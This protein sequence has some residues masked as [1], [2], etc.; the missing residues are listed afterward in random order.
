M[1]LGSFG[2]GFIGGLAESVD[3]EIQK[4][5][6][7]TKEYV[8][9]MAKYQALRRES[10]TKDRA[11]DLKETKER[12]KGLT[13]FAGSA[14]RATRLY[15][16][17]GSGAAVDDYLER[18]AKAKA[19]GQPITLDIPA[20][21]RKEISFGT[22]DEGAEYLTPAAS[23]PD[24]ADD[25][26]RPKNLASAITGMF[27]SK[28]L[29]QRANKRAAGMA[30]MPED[31][32]DRSQPLD[33]SGVKVGPDPFS[34][35]ELAQAKATL[36]KTQAE[37]LPDGSKPREYSNFQELLTDLSDKISKVEPGTPEEASLKK[38]QA[39]VLQDL[40]DFRK[41]EEAAKAA[42]KGPD[43]DK[44][45]TSPFSKEGAQAIVRRSVNDSL[46]DGG[47]VDSLGNR[48]DTAI[49]GNESDYIIR[50]NNATAN[51]LVT[52]NSTA[53]LA[54]WPTMKAALSS[55][56]AR[57][58]DETRTFKAK[59][60]NAFTKAKQEDLP[61]PEGIVSMTAA[62]AQSA[63]SNNELPVGTTVMI[64]DANGG[65]LARIWTGQKFL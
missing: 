58:V 33:A 47:Y 25:I 59:Q 30:P 22:I 61:M 49:K 1:G 26:G 52:Y 15:K 9:D 16:H 53:D 63:A 12:L 39:K 54:K 42:G 27:G 40:E 50:L 65:L 7:E 6:T 51:T 62:Q 34:T 5:M 2:K 3:K 28:D 37:A 14:D 43:K 55:A 32:V 23:V 38:R 57:A 8:N 64:E 17:L 45:P 46:V 18:A 60:K 21:R 24:M 20:P 56:Q 44:E 31:T 35:T 41:Q 4:G 13:Q 19:A 48:I 11:A 36:A 29:G 10:A